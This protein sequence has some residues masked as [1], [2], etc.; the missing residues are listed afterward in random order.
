[1]KLK[2]IK[3]ADVQKFLEDT[4][5]KDKEKAE[6]IFQLREIVFKIFPNVTERIIY[7]GIMF[8]LEKDFGGIFVSKKHVSFEFTN[9]YEMKDP[10]QFLEGTGQYRRHLKIK[11]LS[12]IKEKTV[13]FFVKQ[14]V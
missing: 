9:G 6:V 11:L 10:N 8:S 3:N 1:M 2:K 7:G 13:D 4:I 12:E 14:V 5:L